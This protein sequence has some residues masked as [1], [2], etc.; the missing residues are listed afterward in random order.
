MTSLPLIYD[1]VVIFLPQSLLIYYT[2]HPFIRSTKHI[3]KSTAK[4]FPHR[5]A[6]QTLQPYIKISMPFRSHIDANARIKPRQTPHP[7]PVFPACKYIKEKAGATQRHYPTHQYLT[8]YASSHT[9]IHTYTR[10]R[11]ILP[12]YYREF[13]GRLRLSLPNFQHSRASLFTASFSSFYEAIP[14]VL[15]LL[16]LHARYIDQFARRAHGESRNQRQ[17]CVC[18]CASIGI[19]TRGSVQCTRVSV[20]VYARSDFYGALALSPSFFTRR[21]LRSFFAC[22]G[23][24]KEGERIIYEIIYQS[25]LCSWELQDRSRACIRVLGVGILFLGSCGCEV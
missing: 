4:T 17:A 8:L 11:K 6:V 25:P 7:S 22:V 12:F 20:H 18:V 10:K 24:G 15:L 1:K 21:R 16:L 19:A 23:E 5:I 13:M 14:P 9:Y 3:P 2:I